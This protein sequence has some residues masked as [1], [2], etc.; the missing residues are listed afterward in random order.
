[1]R[2]RQGRG[3]RTWL[4]AA[5]MVLEKH[6]NVPMS[7]KDI[8]KG[9]QKE[10][11]K[12]I[13]YV[14][15]PLNV[16][17]AML[18]SNARNISGIFYKIP[19]K[20][21]FYKLKSFRN[22]SRTERSNGTSSRSV[23][24]TSNS[25]ARQEAVVVSAGPGVPAV[26]GTQAGAR[27]GHRA[28]TRIAV[29]RSTRE[30]V[31]SPASNG[32]GQSRSVSVSQQH[33]RKALKQALW[34]HRQRR[35]VARKL[36]SCVISHK[37]RQGEFTPE[38]QLRL[39][40]E[41]DKE[42]PVQQWKEHF[43][44]DYYGQ[45]SGLSTIKSK[46]LVDGSDGRESHVSCTPNGTPEKSEGTSPIKVRDPKALRHTLPLWKALGFLKEPPWLRQQ[47]GKGPLVAFLEQLWLEQLCQA[48][49]SLSPRS[50]SSPGK[51][52]SV[53]TPDSSLPLVRHAR[54]PVRISSRLAVNGER[55]GLGGAL[56]LVAASSNTSHNGTAEAD[57]GHFCAT[58]DT[59]TPTMH[60]SFPAASATSMP[61]PRASTLGVDNGG[62]TG[63]SR[64][65]R[66]R[67]QRLETWRCVGEAG[68]DVNMDMPQATFETLEEG[69]VADGSRSRRLKG[70]T[71]P[72]ASTA[73]V[74]VVVHQ[75]ALV[76]LRLE[77]SYCRLPS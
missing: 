35:I 50:N 8:L 20:L 55:R 67:K 26:V 38:V 28:S 11:L 70:S 19:G 23:G 42:K 36:V 44:E 7:Q 33:F 37:S 61:R 15:S 22:T 51:I 18:Y 25:R 68:T 4:E 2:D 74:P 34:Q 17:G 32:A 13:G 46:C 9:I 24:S 6:R 41:Q 71:Q 5:R 69:E 39:R 63:R 29:L 57:T 3:D 16:L 45:K 66:L 73:P 47:E 77:H 52:N 56:Q 64:E 75:A 49:G 65:R 21:G 60:A 59:S 30:D 76:V 58:P 14:N 48:N 62:R 54:S 40:Q 27:H 43:F 72:S 1:M 10:K 53:T 12:E 31:A